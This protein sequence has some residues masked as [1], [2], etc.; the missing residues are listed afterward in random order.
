VTEAGV[1]RA[2]PFLT[3]CGA[4]SDPTRERRLYIDT[5]FRVNNEHSA[6][7][8]DAARAAALLLSL[9]SLTATAV[10]VSAHRALTLTF[11]DGSVLTVAGDAAEFTTH[12]IWWLSP[13]LPS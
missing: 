12:D 8:G 7:D 13:S 5:T 3:F 10:D 2:W 4:T 6:G 11:D 1:R 9:N